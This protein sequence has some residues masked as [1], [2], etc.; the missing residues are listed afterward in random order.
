MEWSACEIF[1]ESDEEFLP[2]TTKKRS[3][4]KVGKS[5]K[6]A[7]KR[8]GKSLIIKLPIGMEEADGDESFSERGSRLA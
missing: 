1:E 3:L 6:K 2:N 4:G 7:A 5:S 8:V